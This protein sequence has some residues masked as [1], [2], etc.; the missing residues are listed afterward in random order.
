[1]TE[2]D[3]DVVA[4]LESEKEK[5]WSGLLQTKWD[6]PEAKEFERRYIDLSRKIRFAKL[7]A[8]GQR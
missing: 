4:E 1:M 8:A 3:T 5:A 2:T 6:S 7:R